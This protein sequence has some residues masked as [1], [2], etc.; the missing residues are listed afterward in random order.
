MQAAG[1]VKPLVMAEP[2]YQNPTRRILRNGCF[3]DLPTV[4]SSLTPRK[5][6]RVLG[7]KSFRCSSHY[8]SLDQ[9]LEPYDVIFSQ[10]VAQNPT[11]AFIQEAIH[12]LKSRPV[13]LVLAIG[14]G[15]VLDVSKLLASIPW[16]EKTDLTD[17]IDRPFDLSVRSLPLVALPTTAGTG[18]E[19]TPYAS[20]ETHEKK[21]ITLGHPFF[22]PSVA[23]IDPELCY[24]MPAYVTACTGFDAL[25]QAIESF[26]SMNATPFSRTHALRA[27]ALILQ[28]FEKAYQNPWNPEARFDMSLASCEAGLAIAQTKTTA[29]HSVSY[30]ITAH[31]QVAH[32]HACALTLA[33]FVRFNAPVLKEEGKPLLNVL[34]TSSYEAAA[35]KIETLMRQ[36]SLERSLSKLGIDD[37]GIDLIIQDGF[38]PDRI[39]NNPRP[40]QAG[41]LK[42]ILKAIR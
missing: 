13:D 41:D 6:L 34:K 23:L 40:V 19:V 3:E 22:Y 32:G 38:R 27:A 31:F 10:P 16:Q 37:E 29:V 1:N 39:K 11:Q 21:K 7:E 8:P 26:W 2:F 18:S 9:M 15:S 42:N 14:G 25:S 36:V 24:S 12:L 5:I 20:L 4:L 28:S 35:Q 30:P 33:E 17:Y